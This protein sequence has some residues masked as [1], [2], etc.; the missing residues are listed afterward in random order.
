[1]KTRDVNFSVKQTDQIEFIIDYLQNTYPDGDPVHWGC[2]IHNKDIKDGQPV[3]EHLHVAIEFTNPR[4]IE[5]IADEFRLPSHMI[6]KTRSKRAIFRY[7]IHRDNPEK[8]QYSV[9][10]ILANFNYASYF[11]DKVDDMERV[12]EAWKDY[13]DL[14]KGVISANEYIKRRQ[15]YLARLSELQLLQFF[16]NVSKVDAALG[17]VYKCRV[18]SSNHN[19]NKELNDEY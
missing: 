2:I 19:H 15:I 18:R 11:I 1:M 13:K 6:E 7:L 14:R 10:D 3:G 8:A 17:L 12:A 16:V 5:S 9:S 4:S